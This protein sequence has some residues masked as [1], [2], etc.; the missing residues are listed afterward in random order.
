[1]KKLLSILLVLCMI[2][3]TLPV[4]VGAE[5]STDSSNMQ[6]LESLG[7]NTNTSVWKNNLVSVTYPFVK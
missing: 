3:S 5:N 7:F 2:I 4:M 6:V 1:M